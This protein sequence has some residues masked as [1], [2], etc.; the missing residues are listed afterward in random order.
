MRDMNASAERNLTLSSDPQT[1]AL[2]KRL[3]MKITCHSMTSPQNYHTDII[4]LGNERS[5]GFREPIH[6]PYAP[7]LSYDRR[8]L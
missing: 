6:E 7:S 2:R 8:S 1:T 4:L 3:N 5:R